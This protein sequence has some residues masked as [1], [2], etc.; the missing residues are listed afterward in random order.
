VSAGGISAAVEVNRTIELFQP[1]CVLLVGV[2]GGLKDVKLGDVVVATKVYS[3]EFGKASTTF[4]VRPNV[5]NTPYRVVEQARAQA[6]KKNWLRRLETPPNP[7]PRVLVGP[8]ASG[9][10]IITSTASA[11]WRFLE[12]QYSDA[13]AVEMEGQDFLFTTQGNKQTMVL[14]IRG[15]SDLINSKFSID[16][17][18]TQELAARNASAFAF[19]ILATPSSE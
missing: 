19:E 16:A 13:L 6:R 7:I 17:A 5:A 1:D 4:K 10:K 15:I 11:L 2:A 3:F 8:I 18:N 12:E 14:T 9:E